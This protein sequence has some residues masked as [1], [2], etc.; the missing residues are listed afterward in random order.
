MELQ[1][2]EYLVELD[3]VFR[4]MVRKFVKERD[5][6][7]VE[8]ITL[9]GF[10]I[11]RKILVAGKQ[12]LSDLADELDLSSGA[13]TAQCD[14][15]EE[16]GLAERIR[17]KEDRRTIYLDITTE[18]KSLLKRYEKLGKTNMGIMFDGLTEQ[19]LKQQLHIT[20][21]ILENIEGMSDKMLQAIEHY[22]QQSKQLEEE[23]ETTQSQEKVEGDATVHA[24]QSKSN[25]KY[26]SY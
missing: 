8:G 12:R 26:L 16:N 19:E 21:R 15:L 23:V 13:I 7:I 9:P 10:M 14:K 2:E 6:I 11:L 1:N 22:A 20:K 25:P 18:G 4:K 24:E 17:Y 5:K 3:H